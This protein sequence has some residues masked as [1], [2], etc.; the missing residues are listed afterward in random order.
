MKSMINFFDSVFKFYYRKM[1]SKERDPEIVPIFIL[2]YGQSANLLIV[3]VVFC[4]FL[5]LHNFF[6]STISL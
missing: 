3:Y 1:E 5:D 2:S 6:I 4:F